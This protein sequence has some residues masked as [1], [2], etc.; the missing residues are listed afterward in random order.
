MKSCRR[1]N[2]PGSS[3][4]KDVQISVTW[5]RG[6]WSHGTTALLAISCST[7]AGTGASFGMMMAFYLHVF[8]SRNNAL[9]IGRE[10][11]TFPEH[12][13]Y[14]RMR[15]A[16][17]VTCSLRRRASSSSFSRIQ[18]ASILLS[19][20]MHAVYTGHGDKY[21]GISAAAAYSFVLYKRLQ[22]LV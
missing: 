12:Y 20:Q 4:P 7:R 14:D 8:V 11:W 15:L 13:F 17:E 18:I 10:A 19:D 21:V 3:L 1:R 9:W 2:N 22:I 6:C 5:G 16:T